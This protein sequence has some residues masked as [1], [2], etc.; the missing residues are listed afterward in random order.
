[1]VATLGE[2]TA[3]SSLPRWRDA[4]LAD[5]DGRR[6]LRDRPRVN[7][8]TVDMA[9]LASLPDHTF[10]ATYFRWLE[11]CGVTP[12]SRNAVCLFPLVHASLC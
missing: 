3:G 8:T 5:P 11:R 2:T 4:M 12:D 6:I 10:G 1:M 7:T 9:Y